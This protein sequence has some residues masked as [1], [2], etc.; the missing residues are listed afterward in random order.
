[1]C[2]MEA[3]RQRVYWLIPLAVFL[4]GS[5]PGLF[6]ADC[7]WRDI[8][9]FPCPT[10]GM[11]RAFQGVIRGDL[12][13]AWQM[14]PLIFILM[15]LFVFSAVFAIF[16]L[17]ERRRDPKHFVWPTNF[18]RRAGLSLAALVFAVY[19]IRMVLLFPTEEPLNW[20]DR[21]IIPLIV[22][23]ILAFFKR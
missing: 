13:R 6:L 17:L 7:F 9:G 2:S 1:M 18:L 12:A 8:F 20:N 11:T 19:I 23:T 4:L 10:C 3:N 14:H 5:V 15:P 21:A 16:L 22:Q